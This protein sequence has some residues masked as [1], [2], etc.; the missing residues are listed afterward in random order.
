MSTY[1]VRYTING[2]EYSQFDI[3][4]RCAEICLGYY[5]EGF[6]FV[7][8]GLDSSK[9]Y[10]ENFP[11]QKI[12]E[13]KRHW[14]PFEPCTNWQSAGK[15]IDKCFDDLMG[16]HHIDEMVYWERLMMVHNCTKLVAA[17]I[18]LIES[19]EG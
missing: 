16:Y 3:N 13:N 9:H 10:S 18:C 8:T 1:T 15:V 14:K 19:N 6:R 2:K 12:T 7:N 17:C 5:E 11:Y 4:K